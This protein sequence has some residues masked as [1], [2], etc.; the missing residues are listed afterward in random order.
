MSSSTLTAELPRPAETSASL[1]DR[2]TYAWARQ[3]A[4]AL[5]RRDFEA[6]DWDHVIEEIEDVGLAERETWISGCAGA[7]ERM[8]VVEHWEDASASSLDDLEDEIWACRREMARA[9][10]SNPSL[11]GVHAEML[12]LAWRIGR[13]A[14]VGRLAGYSAEASGAVDD[15]AFVR[16]FDAKLPEECP[17]LAE[18]IAAYDPSVDK[19]PRDDVWPP[20]VAKTFN[21]V[22]GEDYEIAKVPGRSNGRSR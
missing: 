4:D 16:V 11:R 1:Y 2:D 7:I 19:D 13:R 5:R 20:G 3:Q 10:D 18:D 12:H 8:L 15:L 6:V 21:R 22:L 14:A 17:Y 9:V